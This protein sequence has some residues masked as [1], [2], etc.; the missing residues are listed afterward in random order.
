MANKKSVNIDELNP[1][2][3][4]VGPKF[5][6]D[7]PSMNNVEGMGQFRRKLTPK[8]LQRTPKRPISIPGMPEF[9]AQG[10]GAGTPSLA[11]TIQTISGKHV[12]YYAFSNFTPNASISIS[13]MGGGGLSMKTSSTG[14]GSGNFTL[15]EGPGTYTLVASDSAGVRASKAFTIPGSSS[16]STPVAVSQPA[17]APSSNPPSLAAVVNVVGGKRVLYWAFSYF[18]PNS[19]V[20]ISVSGGGGISAKADSNGKGTGNFTVGEGAGTYTLTARDSSGKQASRQFTVTATV[21][22]QTPTTPTKTT[23]G[24]PIGTKIPSFN[25]IVNNT[26]ITIK[27]KDALIRT[28]YA[29]RL[30]EWNNSKVRATGVATE[31]KA[32]QP[33]SLAAVVNQVSISGAIQL[34]VTWAVAYFTPN[35]TLTIGIQGAS[36]KSVKLD[37]NGKAQGD[38]VPGVQPGN[39]TVVA[40]DSSGKTASKTITIPPPSYE[41][42]AKDPGITTAAKDALIKKFYPNQVAQWEAYKKSVEAN[43]AKVD[44]YDKIV[45]NNGITDKAKDALIRTYYPDKWNDWLSYKSSTAYKFDQAVRNTVDSWNDALGSVRDWAVKVTGLKAELA[46]AAAAKA[47]LDVLVKK[48]SAAKTLSQSTLNQYNSLVSEYQS[49]QKEAGT[50]VDKYNAAASE[51]NAAVSGAKMSGIG[52]APLAIA[53]LAVVGIAALATLVLWFRNWTV[54]TDALAKQA[55]A[56]LLRAKASVETSKAV[57][58]SAD[59]TAK[60]VDTAIETNDE[61]KEQLDQAIIDY[62]AADKVY[63][64][65]PTPENLALVDDAKQEVADLTQELIDNTKETLD[66]AESGAESTAQGA[67]AVTI[68]G[69]GLTTVPTGETPGPAATADKSVLEKFTG[70]SGKTITIIAIAAI[71]IL[72]APKLIS[73]FGASK[74]AAAAK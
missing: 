29:S 2:I 5:G 4:Q 64:E 23:T 52:I 71:L 67:E 72:A 74:I 19:T 49:K 36:S 61:I 47:R 50:Q 73:S 38:F 41:S 22:Q 33:G 34:R 3:V 48:S 14:S 17:P 20:S 68:P 31:T 46:N 42:I 65:D 26:G 9:M 40:K 27:A 11:A 1:L 58:E 35:S 8:R 55:E 45:H 12:L 21:V 53:G 60:A 57:K 66:T 7:A 59:T 32:T 6:F 25:E 44:S 62:Q 15:G 28:Y 69:T 30:T 51:A 70:I 54:K 18:T 39:Y 10:I 37:G 43:K 24:T 63:Q 56:E 13:V 16:S